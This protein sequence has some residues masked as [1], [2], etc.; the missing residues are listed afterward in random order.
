MRIAKLIKCKIKYS[1]GSKK[2][3]GLKEMELFVQ[4]KNLKVTFSGVD[5]KG[6]ADI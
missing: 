5:A 1:D 2:V 3:S 6:E 4:F